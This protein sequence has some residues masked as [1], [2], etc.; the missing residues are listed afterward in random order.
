MS[1]SLGFRKSSYSANESAC[2]EVADTPRASIVRDTQHRHAEALAFPSAEWAAA[3]RA[4]R[5]EF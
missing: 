1:S 5:E 2:A 4:T 3:V